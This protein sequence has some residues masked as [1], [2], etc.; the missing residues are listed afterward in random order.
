ML[1]IQIEDLN[2][3]YKDRKSQF[4]E[5]LKL[6]KYLEDMEEKEN[7]TNRKSVSPRPA[8][9]SA[10]HEN[11]QKPAAFDCAELLAESI[12]NDDNNYNK[13]I[14]YTHYTSNP[15]SLTQVPNCGPLKSTSVIMNQ[16]QSYIPVSYNQEKSGM[17]GKILQV[18]LSEKQKKAQLVHNFIRFLDDFYEEFQVSQNMFQSFYPK[19][20]QKLLQKKKPNVTNEKI[21]AGIKTPGGFCRDHM[22]NMS[23]LNNNPS[24]YHCPSKL[25]T[26]TFIKKEK[27]LNKIK[28]L[29]K[30]QSTVMQTLL[31]KIDRQVKPIKKNNQQVTSI[32]E[33]KNIFLEQENFDILKLL[34]NRNNNKSQI[35]ELLSTKK[36]RAPET[37]EKLQKT[38]EQS[39]T[40]KRRKDRENADVTHFQSTVKKTPLN[41]SSVTPSSKF[42]KAHGVECPK[43]S[44]FVFNNTKVLT[45]RGKNVEVDYQ[46]NIN[47]VIEEELR[48]KIVPEIDGER[49]SQDLSK[50]DEMFMEPDVQKNINLEY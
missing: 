28:M 22:A 13:L 15:A 34:N 43:P 3:T 36:R 17:H 31:Q 26:L 48:F 11:N 5:D 40:V 49:S 46:F 18:P 14:P 39:H 6:F 45:P 1:E 44:Q 27:A 4:A 2:K 29:G 7:I 19:Q 50:I 47:P 38:M 24:T 8:K 33:K 9:E 12:T 20:I 41:R 21:I 37:I 16:Q 42:K 35:R 30:L 32:L 10:S 23:Q 25:S